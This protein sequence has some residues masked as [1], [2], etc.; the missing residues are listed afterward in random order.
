MT[1]SGEDLDSCLIRVSAGTTLILT[2][3]FVVFLSPSG[4]NAGVVARLCYDHFLQFLPV[5][6]PS[7]MRQCVI[8]S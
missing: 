6:H 4:Q 3:G 1:L 5:H 8:S 7:V 2:Q